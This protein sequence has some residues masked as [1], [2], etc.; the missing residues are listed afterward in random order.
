MVDSIEAYAILASLVRVISF[1]A[2]SKGLYSFD[3]SFPKRFVV[4]NTKCRT[5][6]WLPRIFKNAFITMVPW[7]LNKAKLCCFCVI[8]ILDNFF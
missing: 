7:V 2:F 3:V 8:S 5:L 1:A 4:V 6:K